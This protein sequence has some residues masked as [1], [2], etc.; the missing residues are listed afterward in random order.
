M[1]T[2]NSGNLWLL[3][4]TPL[5]LSSSSFLFCSLYVIMF[6]QSPQ[7]CYFW[8]GCPLF[9]STKHWP[10]ITPTNGTCWIPSER[11]SVWNKMRSPVKMTRISL[12]PEPL[13]SLTH[14]GSSA[15][16]STYI[17]IKVLLT[18]RSKISFSCRNTLLKNRYTFPCCFALVWCCST[19]IVMLYTNKT[20]GSSSLCVCF[21]VVF[22]VVVG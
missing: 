9:F 17:L 10:H 8:E 2:C 4:L 7:F 15:P 20:G 5:C 11:W 19:R 13:P 16:S 12:I 22:V 21:F 14:L 1:I 6:H 3:M 18:C